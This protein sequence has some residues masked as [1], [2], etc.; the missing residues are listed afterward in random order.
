MSIQEKLS[1]ALAF[2]QQGQ[3]LEAGELYREILAEDP[4]QVDALNLMGVVMQ[5]A[6]DLEVALG[7]FGTS[8]GIGT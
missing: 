4:D 2:H 6:G 3:L 8:N 1:T 7:L 5:A